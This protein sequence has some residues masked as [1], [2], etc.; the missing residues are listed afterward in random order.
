MLY[1][2]SVKYVRPLEEVQ[3]HLEAHKQWLARHA[4]AGRILVAG[5]FEDKS[6]GLALASCSSRAELDAMIA[7]DSF[8]LH[9]L[10][11]VSV[12]GFE[13]AIRA[14]AFAPQCAGNAAVVKA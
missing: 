6:G 14:E 5:P 7:E 3:A 10:V 12:Q 2:V 4:A 1:I 13:P 11:L 8:V 9:Q